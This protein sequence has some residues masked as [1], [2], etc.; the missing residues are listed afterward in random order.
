MNIVALQAKN[1]SVCNPYAD[2][3]RATCKFK[4][5]NRSSCVRTVKIATSSSEHAF[6]V[7]LFYENKGSRILVALREFRCQKQL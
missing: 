7:K 6:N 3:L 4:E 5:E 1:K 2:G